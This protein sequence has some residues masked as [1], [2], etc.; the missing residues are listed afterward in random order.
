MIMPIHAR[1]METCIKYL[2]TM[3]FW[4]SKLIFRRLNPLCFATWAHFYFCSTLFVANTAPKSWSR[5]QHKNI[6]LPNHYPAPSK[7]NMSKYLIILL[8]P[9]IMHFA[10]LRIGAGRTPK[11]S[12]FA[13][14]VG[15][16]AK[17]DWNRTFCLFGV[18][19][20]QISTAT[21]NNVNGFLNS[22]HALHAQS[23]WLRRTLICVKNEVTQCVRKRVWSTWR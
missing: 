20:W 6:R 16:N 15:S 21:I 9:L 4:A 12:R 18:L 10:T 23:M 2:R 13:N 1:S 11:P 7:A 5:K 19:F 3:E 8:E 17:K 22:N 14:D